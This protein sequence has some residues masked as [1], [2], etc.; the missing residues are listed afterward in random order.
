V[1]DLDASVGDQVEMGERI[2]RVEEQAQAERQGV[3]EAQ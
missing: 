2:M 1:R 3:A